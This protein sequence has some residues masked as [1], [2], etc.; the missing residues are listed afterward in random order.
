MVPALDSASLKATLLNAGWPDSLVSEYNELIENEPKLPASI[1]L[2]G[3]TKSF[4]GKSVLNGVNFTIAP[5][6]L[7][8][9]IGLSGAGKTTLLNILVGFLQPDAGTI[10]LRLPNGQDVE[11]E[12]K[13]ELVKRMVGFSAQHPSFYPKLTVR[14][15]IEHFS[16]LYQVPLEQRR[17]LST[18]LI[19][20]VG[21]DG[22]E[23]VLAQNLSGGMQKRLDIAC[24]MVHRPKILILDE[25]TA[26]LDPLIRAQLW[27]L[28][29]AI[30]SQGTTI[31]VAS[32]FIGELE[33]NCSKIAVLNHGI[34]A[35]VDSVDGYR[36]KNGN[37]YEITLEPSGSRNELLEIL[38]SHKNYERLVQRG[39]K[40]VLYTSSPKKALSEL[41]ALSSDAGIKMKSVKLDKP[42]LAE[43]V[44]N[45]MSP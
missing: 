6:E 34:I 43:L 26:D 5:G 4:E 45:L 7:F 3:I 31:I 37:L 17:E 27:K 14:E 2:T 30:N 36:K 38:K 15:N 41:V 13:L 11:L 19:R 42:S 28:I 18:M 39:N 8:G 32:H 21:L 24:A 40:V 20:G 22:S 16:A 9:I 10:F 29:R 12:K 44:H 1:I 35:D 23:N 33:R 25:P